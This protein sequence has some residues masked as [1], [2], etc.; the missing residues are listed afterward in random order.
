MSSS[1]PARRISDVLPLPLRLSLADDED[2]VL[3][4]TTENASRRLTTTL[5]R[6][7]RACYELFCDV[8]RVPAWLSVVRSAQ[9]VRR[10][11]EERPLEVAFLAR[12]E[13]ATVGYTCRYVY[14]ADRLRVG[15]A[16][17]ARARIRVA[18]FAEFEPLG[19]TACLVSYAL[20]LGLGASGAL[21]A[22]GD[23]LLENHATSTSLGDFRDYVLRAL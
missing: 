9:V 8:S 12:L 21:P 18:G 13:G 17:S 22:W 15:F 6:P 14:A 16:T 19:D 11:A 10:D 2:V 7:A 5:P 20:E 3:P 23:P 4:D 1:F